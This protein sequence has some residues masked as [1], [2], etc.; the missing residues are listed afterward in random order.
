MYIRDLDHVLHC[1]YIDGR[2]AL[3]LSTS[4][5][6]AAGLKAL[7][8]SVGGC[9]LMCTSQ[10]YYLYLLYRSTFILL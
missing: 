4:I 2:I 3:N 6:S 8:P 1:Y 10:P 5:Q 7:K 9:Y